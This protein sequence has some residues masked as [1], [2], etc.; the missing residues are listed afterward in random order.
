[1]IVRKKKLAIK[2]LRTRAVERG[3]LTH[4]AEMGIH[5]DCERGRVWFKKLR[6][7]ERAVTIFRRPDSTPT[8]LVYREEVVP[9]WNEDF[10][11]LWNEAVDDANL[12]E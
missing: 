8:E 3:V 6:T 10:A 7:E 1:M 4:G 5:G 2:V 9:G 11:P 12:R